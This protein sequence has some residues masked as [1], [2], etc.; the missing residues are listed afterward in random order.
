MSVKWSESIVN[1]GVLAATKMLQSYA[2]LLLH[3][4]KSVT[5][6]CYLH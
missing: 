4:L 5:L 6:L 3:F 2:T 1:K